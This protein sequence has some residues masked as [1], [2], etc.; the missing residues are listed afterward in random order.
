MWG[1]DQKSEEGV[2]NEN[3]RINGL[4]GAALDK[5]DKG[6]HNGYRSTQR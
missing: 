2:K 4:C 6:A 3:E 1:H 5:L